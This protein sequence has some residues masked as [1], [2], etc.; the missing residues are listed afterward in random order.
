[1]STIIGQFPQETVT[2]WRKSTVDT[3]SSPYGGGWDAPVTFDAR[4][5]NGGAIRRDDEQEEFQPNTTYVTKYASVQ[6]GDMIAV[7]EHADL[8]PV[9]GAEKIVKVETATPLVG[10][11]DYMLL[12]G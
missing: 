7:G 10:G 12:T 4:F 3:S 1:M 6:K 8:T 2:I 9:S 5:K 11:K